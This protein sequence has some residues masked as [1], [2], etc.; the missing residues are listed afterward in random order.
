MGLRLL[1]GV[2]ILGCQVEMFHGVL[3]S[4]A[5][6]K[7][8]LAAKVVDC[9]ALLLMVLMVPLALGLSLWLV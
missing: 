8:L 5:L 6:V 9:A 4:Q 2:D 1:D 7:D 3:F